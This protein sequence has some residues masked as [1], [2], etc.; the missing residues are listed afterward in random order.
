MDIDRLVMKNADAK[1]H[2]QIAM[3]DVLGFIIHPCPQTFL[4]SLQ[5]A[6]QGFFAHLHAGLVHAPGMINTL[7]SLLFGGINPLS[8]MIG[9]K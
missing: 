7:I 3:K 5:R 4:L 1:Q 6:Q 2:T 8:A 9:I